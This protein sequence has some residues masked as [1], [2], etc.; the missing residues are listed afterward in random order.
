MNIK[1]LNA[2]RNKEGRTEDV[3]GARDC[4]SNTDLRHLKFKGE[5]KVR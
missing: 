2:R 5:L 3:S 1:A 4:H